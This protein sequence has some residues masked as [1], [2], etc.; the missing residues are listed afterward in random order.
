MKK[1]GINLFVV[2]L[3]LGGLLFYLDVRYDERFERHVSAQ[4]ENYVEK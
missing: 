3:I 4:V 1:I 2:F